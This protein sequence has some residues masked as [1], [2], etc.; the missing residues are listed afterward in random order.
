MLLKHCKCLTRYRHR[1]D[2]QVC[3]IVC[4]YRVRHGTIAG[5]G[6]A[7]GYCN[8]GVIAF[9]RPCAAGCCRYAYAV[10]ACGG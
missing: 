6:T 4:G 3:G 10:T 9:C 5:A 8:P 1:A 2:P 7:G